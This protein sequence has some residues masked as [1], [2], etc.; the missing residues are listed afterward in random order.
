M[1][2]VRLAIAAFAVCVA[3]TWSVPVTRD[4]AAAAPRRPSAP[5]QDLE[6][7]LGQGSSYAALAIDHWKSY[8][9]SRGWDVTYT[10]TNSVE[11]LGAY[12]Q[13]RADYAATEAEF[14]SLGVPVQQSAARG[15]Q[16]T[17]TVAGAIAVMYNVNDKAGNDVSNLRLSR[18]TVARIFIGD[19]TRWSDP[20]IT[21]DNGGKELPDEAINVIYRSGMSGTTALFYDFVQ[22]TVPDLFNSWAQR[23][24]FRTDIRLIQTD[25]GAEYRGGVPKGS[26]YSGSDQMAQIVASSGG[27]WSIGATEAG[28]AY[29]N[30]ANVAYVQN[31]SG[32]WVRPNARSITVALEGAGLRGDISQGLEAVYTNPYADAYPISAYSYLVTQC[33]SPQVATCVGRYPRPGKEATL[34]VWMRYI[35]CEG[36]SEMGRGIQGYAP[37]PPHLSQEIA[38]SIGRMTASAPETLTPENCGNP[39]FNPGYALPGEDPLPPEV[40]A[41]DPSAAGDQTTSTQNRGPAGSDATAAAAAADATTTSEEAAAGLAGGGARAV[42]GGSGNWREADPRSYNRPGMSP[43]EIWTWVAVI[44]VLVMPLIFG[45]VWGVVR[46]PRI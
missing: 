29:D 35:A 28:Y 36:Q 7:V 3:G 9:G 26:G 46:R 16:Y 4:P 44:A 41:V 32:N 19:I 27:K 43:V 1:G 17:P 45:I 18:R 31:E 15:F 13:S 22:H 5:A 2:R 10:A 33:D 38:N 39:R 21:A 42:G 8:A 23:N 30:H 14:S 40:N 34:A 11:G 37:L 24:A 25:T 6:A 20:A 12:G